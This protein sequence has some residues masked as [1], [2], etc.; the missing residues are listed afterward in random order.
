MLARGVWTHQASLSLPFLPW[1]LFRGVSLLR[2]SLAESD[3]GSW[4]LLG[5]DSLHL[6]PPCS[7][8]GPGWNIELAEE[9]SDLRG[10]ARPSCQSQVRGQTFYNSE[11]GELSEHS[12]DG[13]CT[14]PGEGASPSALQA[15]FFSEQ[16]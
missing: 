5:T 4:G 11:Y 16:Y 2:G 14:P 8:K 1:Q 13:S 15:S 9:Q 6:S 12:E 7:S 3:G 10:R